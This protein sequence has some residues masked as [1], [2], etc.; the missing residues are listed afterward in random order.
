MYSLKNVVFFPLLAIVLSALVI[1]GEPRRGF[2]QADSL[3]LEEPEDLILALTFE[4]KFILNQ[5]F[6][7]VLYNG[8][9][10][11]P[12]VELAE[13]FSFAVD[14]DSERRYLTG[15]YINPDNT[16]TI[17]TENQKLISKGQE[18]SLSDEDVLP[19]DLSPYPEDMF[20]AV[21]VLSEIW[22]GIQVAVDLASLSISVTAED[23]LPFEER[24]ERGQKR[25]KAL[26][27]RKTREAVK[28]VERPLLE[29]PYQALGRPTIDVQAET[30]LDADENPT[31]VTVTG[32]QDLL[33]TTADFGASLRRID[34]QLKRPDNVRLRLRRIAQGEEDLG[35]G[36]REV[37][38]GDIRLEQRDLV[39]NA[40]NGRGVAFTTSP[41]RE[42]GE[43]DVVTVEG[44][45]PAG[46]EVELYRNNELLEFGIVGDDGLYRFEDVPLLF[47]NNEIRAILFGPEGQVR[48]DVYNFNIGRDQVEPGKTEFYG[49]IVDTNEDFIPIRQ[50]ETQQAEGTTVS[51]YAFHGINK[52]LTLFGGY[53]QVPAQQRD[54]LQR[55]SSVGAVIAALGGV[56]QIEG[57]KQFGGG[58]AIDTRF[59]TDFKE[60]SVNL[61]LSAYNDFESPDAGFDDGASD[62]EAELELQRNFRLPFGV[63]GVRVDNEYVQ[64]VSGNTTLSNLLQQ[65]LTWRGLR[66]S[67]TTRTQWNNDDLANSNGQI[68]ATYRV[69][70]W[71]FRP[72]LNYQTFPED[73]ISSFNGE[74]RYQGDDY[75]V[76]FNA[77]HAFQEATTS[78]GIAFSKEFDQFLGT[79]DTQWDSEEGLSLIL[80]ATT[81]IGPFGKE[82]DYILSRNKLSSAA[83]IR[84]RVFLDKD[85]DGAFSEGTD[86]PLEDA[87]ISVGS[88]RSSNV[89]DEN[90]IVTEFQTASYKT[91]PV[92]VDESSVDDPY[93]KRATE[94]YLVQPR[95]GTLPFVD[96]PMVETG[97]IDGSVFYEETGEPVQGLSLQ[98]LNDKG[99]ILQST[100]TAYDGFY[101]FEFVPPGTYTVR[102]DPALG[103]DIPAETI[104]VDPD[105]LLV[106]GI[107][108]PLFSQPV[109]EGSGG[110][111]SEGQE[112]FGPFEPGQAPYGPYLPAN[113][114][115]EEDEEDNDVFGPALPPDEDGA[116]GMPEE[117]KISPAA[118]LSGLGVMK[119]GDAGITQVV[120]RV[121]IGEHPDKV[122]LVLDLSGPADFRTMEMADARGAIIELPGTG[123]EAA[124]AWSADTTPILSGY[125]AEGLQGAGSRLILN[126][127]SA[128]FIEAIGILPPQ[129]KSGYRLY[130][131][132]VKTRKEGQR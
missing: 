124:M 67:N 117:A 91:V 33:G 76:A 50:D 36:V 39:D 17:D 53:S 120:S 132:L 52:N 6:L 61:R 129:E 103:V 99:D 112:P 28:D 19:A 31:Q 49:G 97:A 16:F 81:S 128:L 1:A 40:V 79:V 55:Y 44:V 92:F 42:Q 116:E 47:G 4:N 123:W 130:V 110:V 98:L 131:D 26:A 54:V 90:G 23:K 58:Q 122:R 88:R 115:D 111:P 83:P 41:F 25:E 62:Y 56:A 94:G 89:T 38:G 48:E 51:G 46:W 60:V 43:F 108:L 69:R 85:L 7:G 3:S 73:L 22:P 11:L 2:A 104:I 14:F 65:T 113:K 64:D 13:E 87:S 119:A 21:E 15:W 80:R 34:G 106:S 82:R 105:E 78:G 126:A 95:P 107:D 24:L 75:S 84:A 70:K 125:A 30:T 109:S 37:R 101:A 96:L 18:T 77:T 9:Y 102:P 127:R 121:R 86:E 8:M 20:V 29:N 68:S 12:V 32:V 35:F 93:Y 27:R 66:L 63:L 74:I 57:Y 118:G 5:G 72:A 45:A 10:Y 114:Q 71:R 59:L 100:E